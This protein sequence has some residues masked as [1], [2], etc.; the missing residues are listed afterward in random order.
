MIEFGLQI[1]PEQC[2]A[3]REHAERCRQLFAQATKGLDAVLTLASP[4]EAP[5]KQN[6][7]GSPMFNRTW[8]SIGVPCLGLPFGKGDQGLPLA[9]QFVAA[10]GQDHQLLALGGKL[11]SLLAKG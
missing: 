8:T 2:Q 3:E 5:L 11:E 4:G 10:E 6:G 7:T 1:T 9:V